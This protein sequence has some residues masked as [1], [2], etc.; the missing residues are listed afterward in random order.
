[1]TVYYTV[2]FRP[3]SR[4]EYNEMEKYCESTGGS[5][6]IK[7]EKSFDNLQQYYR[8]QIKKTKDWSIEKLKQV[9]SADTFVIVQEL[10]NENK[11][12]DFCVNI[13]CVIKKVIQDQY[14]KCCCRVEMECGENNCMICMGDLKSGVK[15]ECGKVFHKRCIEKW[16]KINNSC[17][18]C[19]K[20]EPILQRCKI[21]FKKN[22]VKVKDNVCKKVKKIKGPTVKELKQMCKEKGIRGYSKLRKVELLE[23]LNL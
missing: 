9:L 17:P 18:N 3:M 14:E 22:I 21:Y 12:I 23:L 20:E 1:M 16:L 7:L 11:P 19:R 13:H 10:L 8:R 5:I 4:S 15:T 2:V 6:K